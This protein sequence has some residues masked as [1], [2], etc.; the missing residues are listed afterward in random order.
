MGFENEFKGGSFS[1]FERTGLS[2]QERSLDREGEL[3]FQEKV[4]K[5]RMGAKNIVKGARYIDS[6]RDF[7]KERG[8]LENINEDACEEFV[9]KHP[10]FPF[11]PAMVRSIAEELEAERRSQH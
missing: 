3:D 5:L 2:Q 9:R 10:E 6:I 8:G 7:I 1:T 11:E 4:E